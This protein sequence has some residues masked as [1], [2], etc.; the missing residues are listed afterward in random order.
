[1]WGIDLGSCP[2]AKVTGKGS[3]RDCNG[4]RSWLYLARSIK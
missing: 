2:D 3:F 1:M 4:G